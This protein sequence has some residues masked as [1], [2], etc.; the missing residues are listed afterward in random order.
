[1]A[2]QVLAPPPRQRTEIER[3]EPQLNLLLPAQ[4]LDE[5]L[6]HSLRRQIHEWRH[7]EKLPPLQLTSKPV[8]VRNIWGDYDYKKRGAVSSA[9]LH[10]A[11]IGGIIGLTIAGRHVVQQVKQQETVHL[12]APDPSTYMPLSTK[13]NDTISGGGGGGD[14]DKIVAPKGKLPK[15]SMQQ[16]TPPAMVI[17]NDHPKLAVEPTVVVPPQVKM[18]MAANIPN[19]GDPKT[20]VPAG[21]PSNGTGAGGGIGSGAGGGIGSGTGPGLGPGMGGGTGGGVF[22]VGGGVSAPKALY[23]PDPEYSE[24]A[25]KAKYQGTVVLW[26]IVD[27]NG[28][29]RDVKVARTLGMGLDQKAIEAVRNWKFEPA[30]KDGRPVAVQI[31]VEVNFRLY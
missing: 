24:E 1:M 3:K 27:A 10:L 15:L 18:N 4:V 21:P 11:V 12:I 19:F 23:T 22:R 20:A 30:M 14:R 7:P 5:S 2:N 25:R 17:R 29:P 28:R 9:F 13:K 6:W 16:I 8:R 31:N 26:L